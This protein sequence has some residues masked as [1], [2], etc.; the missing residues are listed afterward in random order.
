MTAV[1]KLTA[2]D[3]T[4]KSFDTCLRFRF[5]KERYLPYTLLDAVFCAD[6]LAIGEPAAAEFLLDGVRLHYGLIDTAEAVQTAA[7]CQI[8]VHSRGFTS[9][10]CQNHMVPGTVTNV[11]L[12]SLMESYAVPNVT[13]EGG[14]TA[15]NYVWVKEGSTQWDAIVNYAYKYN[16][17][18]PFVAGANLVRVTNPTSPAQFTLT[19]GQLLRVGTLRDDT[20]MV[21]ELQMPDLQ[22]N[23]SAYTLT[24]PVAAARNIARHRRVPL[25]LQYAASPCDCLVQKLRYSMRGCA[26]VY[27]EYGSYQGEDL[28]DCVTLGGLVTAQRISRVRL[29]GDAGGL[30]TRLWVYHDRYCNEPAT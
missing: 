9:L 22:G 28:E 19:N 7:G 3:G 20:R 23:P 6:D 21:S 2:V 25:D 1:L 13:Y 18:H 27:G 8:T 17:N 26:S 14:I 30:T 11:T 29:T 10:L 24:N 12:Q 4:V 5:E 15:T 16:E